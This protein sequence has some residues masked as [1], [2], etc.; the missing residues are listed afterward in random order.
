MDARSVRRCRGSPKKLRGLGRHWAEAGRGGK[1]ELDSDAAVLG[2]KLDDRY[3]KVEAVEVWPEHLEALDIF[4][5]CGSQW[6]IVAGLA[7]AFYQGLDYTA[8]EAVMRM[9]DVEEP[10]EALDQIREIEAGA[11]EVLNQK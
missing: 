1:D 6:R 8:L 10:G 5:A 7:G 9:R 3:R 11:L 4:Q 2:I